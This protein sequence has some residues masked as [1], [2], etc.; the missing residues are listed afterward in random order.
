MFSGDR[1]PFDAGRVGRRR[2]VGWVIIHWFELGT[3]AL[4]SLNLWFVSAV[5]NALRETN[6]WLA[7][8]TRV[9]WDET[10]GAKQ[11]KEGQHSPP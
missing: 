1:T 7:F 2:G 10:D 6:H 11:A 9:R 4:L 8:L 3:L 5:L